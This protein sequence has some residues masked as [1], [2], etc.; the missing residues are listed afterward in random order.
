MFSDDNN[1]KNAL[2]PHN[3]GIKILIQIKFDFVTI[4]NI[5]CAINFARTHFRNHTVK[6][7]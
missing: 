1:Y 2:D 4:V 5:S 6:S 3:F 7:R